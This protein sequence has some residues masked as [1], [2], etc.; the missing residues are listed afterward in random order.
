[1]PLNLPA[2][3]QTSNGDETITLPAVNN[4]GDVIIASDKF[5]LKNILLYLQEGLLLM[6]DGNGNFQ[7]LLRNAVGGFKELSY[8]GL[9]RIYRFGLG[10]Q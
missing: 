7:P 5:K 8:T 2:L 4:Y 3:C 9:G 1:L 10:I 6:R